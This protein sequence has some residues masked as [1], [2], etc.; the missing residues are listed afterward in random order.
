MFTP[1]SILFMAQEVEQPVLFPFPFGMHI[2][3][4][5]FS[6]VFFG[7]RFKTDKRPYQLIM[8]I[9]IPFS[10]ILWLS[11]SRTVYYFVGIAE[12]IFLLAA[13]V[14]AIIFRKKD[15]PEEEELDEAEETAEETAEAVE[16]AAEET[17]EAVEEAAEETAEA[18]E[19]AAE[20]LLSQDGESQK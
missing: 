1:S 4:A 20:E 16:E 7:W 17:A 10:L 8:A 18:V 9:A 14:T 12:G 15:D 5:L 6:L 2:I 13:L 3:F 19:E 11:D